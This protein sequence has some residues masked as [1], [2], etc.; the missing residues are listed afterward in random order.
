MNN[1]FRKL[2]LRFHKFMHKI[3]LCG[4]CVNDV[5]IAMN[6][7][8]AF[9]KECNAP[10]PTPQDEKPKPENRIESIEC[11]MNDSQDKKDILN[12]PSS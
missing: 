2:L 8:L 10:P 7:I 6:N 12:F 4:L 5:E 11:Q 9:E 1:C 3:I